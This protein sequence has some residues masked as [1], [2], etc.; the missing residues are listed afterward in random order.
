MAA[1]VSKNRKGPGGDD[2]AADG[3][4]V[5]SVGEIHGIAGAHNHQHNENHERDEGQR[6]QMRVVH[7]ALE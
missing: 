2:G 1:D 3:Q 5:Q 4:T 7:Q 6:P